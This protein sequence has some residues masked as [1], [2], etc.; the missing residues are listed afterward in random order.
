[1]PNAYTYRMVR[2]FRSFSSSCHNLEIWNPNAAPLLF[3]MG[4]SG[5][6]KTT[7]CTELSTRYGC[8]CISLDAL[9][10]YDLASP[11]S[12]Q[13]VDKFLRIY[14]HITTSV[15]THWAKQGLFC[16][17]EHAYAEYSQL[18]VQFLY[19]SAIHEQ[20]KYIVEGIQLFARLPKEMLLYQ[21]KIILGTGGLECFRRA[22][23]RDFP[24]FH[25][26]LFPTLIIRFLRYS[27]VQLIRLN[28][29]IAYWERNED[30]FYHQNLQSMKKTLSCKSE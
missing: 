4:L 7:I 19:D 14:P 5:A 30:A 12:R 1:M 29:Y 15:G 13:A 11:E 23:K 17:N 25:L 8:S 21:P 28:R 26:C 6:G 27:T 10:F 18:F 16:R 20:Q 2:L 9:R 3:V 24:R 22:S